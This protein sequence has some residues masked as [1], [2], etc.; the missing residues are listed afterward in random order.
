MIRITSKKTI[1]DFLSG[2]GTDYK[3]R[4]YGETIN[5]T[6][7]ELERCHDQIQWIFPLHET[8][9][10]ASVYPILSREIVDEARQDKAILGNLRSAKDRM[11]RFFGIGNYVDAKK[12][13]SWCHDYNHNLLRVTRI[14]RSLRLFGLEKEA[15]DFYV[16]ALVVAEGQSE[17]GY[18]SIAT[19]DYWHKAMYNDV[20][21]SMQ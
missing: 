7:A 18:L 9:K 16:N 14:I 19:L 4:Y 13:K 3:G 5:W 15:L 11:E 6:D 1:L 8:S 21:E 17:L 20:W 10:H 12:H 2:V